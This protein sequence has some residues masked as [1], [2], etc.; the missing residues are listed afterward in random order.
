MSQ[1]GWIAPI[2]ADRSQDLSF[3]VN[4]VGSAVST[5][6]QFLY[7]EDHNLR[8]F[9]VLPGVSRALA[10]MSTFVIRSWVQKDFWSS[11]GDFDP[12]PYWQSL[13]VPALVLFGEA[14]TNTPSARSAQ[15]LRDL[16]KPE[17]DV[18][19]YPGSGHALQDPPGRGDRLIRNEAL[20][21][22]RDFILSASL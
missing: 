19:I 20:T 5:H 14:D 16:N 15:L 21:E 8:Q 1:G 2:L 22:I 12:L 9:G 13:E 6:Q 4:F 18:R 3:L 7:E 17:I 11:V 10:Y